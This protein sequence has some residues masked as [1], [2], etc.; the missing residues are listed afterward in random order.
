MAKSHVHKSFLH[1]Q[2]KSKHCVGDNQ[3]FEFEQPKI[4]R[5]K[6]DIDDNQRLQIDM[7]KDSRESTPTSL[8]D[9]ITELEEEQHARAVEI[10]GYTRLKECDKRW[11]SEARFTRDLYKYSLIVR[12]NG[13]KYT[14]GYGKCIGIWFRPLPSDHDDEL[15]WPARVTFT[16]TVKSFGI[17][18]D[19]E[20]SLT[21]PKQEYTWKRE[22]TKFRYPAF[23]FD[24]T[25]LC[26]TLIENSQCIVDDKLTIDIHEHH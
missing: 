23:N 10:P 13:L 19:L 2:S 21:I 11:E 4:K 22:A 1:T 6:L 8:F 16:V 25:I 3:S 24:L 12:P 15:E 17:D 9:G 5:M 20:K 18:S 14:K 26:H 7:L